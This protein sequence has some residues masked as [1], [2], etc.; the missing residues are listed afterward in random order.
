MW[1]GIPA[2]A[3]DYLKVLATGK[4]H[5]EGDRHCI[6]KS[7]ILR[8]CVWAGAGVGGRKVDKDPFKLHLIRETPK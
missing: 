7:L 1:Q 6:I 8:V 5:G 3:M 2:A 4:V